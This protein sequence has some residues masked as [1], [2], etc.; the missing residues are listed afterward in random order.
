LFEVLT[1]AQTRKAPPI[2]II[3]FDRAYWTTIINFEALADEGMINRSDMQ[4]FEFA[5]SAEEA[6]KYLVNMGLKVPDL[7][8]R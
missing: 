1:L 6:W 7:E 2:P 4:L 8:N 5:D 3:C